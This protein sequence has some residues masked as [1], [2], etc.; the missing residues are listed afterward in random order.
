ML[1]QSIPRG[2]EKLL[3]RCTHSAS[4]LLLLADRLKERSTDSRRT[5]PAEEEE[6]CEELALVVQ[7]QLQM[8]EL[9]MLHQLH[10]EELLLAPLCRVA[11]P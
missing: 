6:H 3:R 9:V 8:Q 5:G 10:S 2:F 1:F 4:L 7:H 11:V